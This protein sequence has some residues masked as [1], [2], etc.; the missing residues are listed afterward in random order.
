MM[1][2][3]L[4]GLMRKDL[5][6]SIQEEFLYNYE[7]IL[8]KPSQIKSAAKLLPKKSYDI[9]YIKNI[10]RNTIYEIK[11]QNIFKLANILKDILAKSEDDYLLIL[12]KDDNHYELV[13]G[14][15]LLIRTLID[16]K[17]SVNV[18]L[19]NHTFFSNLYYNT[20]KIKQS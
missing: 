11:E 12:E 2:V 1:N 7:G 10:L 16:E 13:Y 8:Y 4:D 19:L 15:D 3:F 9:S 20:H 6:E 14:H 18:K 17:R 5:N